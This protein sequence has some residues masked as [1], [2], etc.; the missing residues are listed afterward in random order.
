MPKLEFYDGTS[1]SPM[2]AVASVAVSGSTGLSVSGSPITASGTIALTLGS[3]LQG[4]SGLSA[5][6]IVSRTGIGAFTSRALT[7]GTGITVTNGDGVS[8]NPT[9]ALSTIDINTQT[10]GQLTASR[11]SGY[12]TS[13]SAFLRGDGTWTLPYI[14]NLLINGS[15]NL[16]SYDLA[17]SGTLSATTG[18]VKT[19]N[20]SSY[21][22]GAVVLG[23]P[24]AMNNYAITGLATPSNAQDAANK[25]YVDTN[26]YTKT[27][28]NS[29]FPSNSQALLLGT[30]TSSALSN[31]YI[32][33]NTNASSYGS[34]FSFF[35]NGYGKGEVGYNNST[36]EL[37]LWAVNTS[38]I[39]LGTAGTT[40]LSIASDGLST[41]SSR[42]NITGGQLGF[43]TLAITRTPATTQVNDSALYLRGFYSGATAYYDAAIDPATYAHNFGQV[44]TTRG[45]KY[46]LVIDSNS[47][48]EGSSIA[49]NGD[50]TQ[51][52]NPFDDL[53]IIFTDEDSAN[54]DTYVSYISSSGSLVVSSSNEKKY[55]V[56][57]KE[58]K[59]YLDRIN[60]LN[61]YSYA[62]KCNVNDSDDDKIRNRKYF[63]NKRLNV[64]LIAEEVEHLFENCTDSYK[65]IDIDESNKD[66]FINLTKNHCIDT[67]E[68]EYVDAKNSNRDGPGIRYDTM[69]CY[70]ILALQELSKK[71]DKLTSIRKL[72]LPLEEI[73]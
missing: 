19:N 13:T 72:S 60:S 32:L 29:N 1:W 42:V 39:K 54:A 28:I 53:G 35:N 3:E 52:I 71:V 61:V 64:G 36:S 6:G 5:A 63:K 22:A 48:S 23:S 34:G 12:P 26:F 7:A 14:N 44:T 9:I 38:S 55:S 25:T 15:V 18:T 4:L 50:Y 10:T 70:T 66:D 69:L 8:G 30:N 16:N 33:N 67:E 59:N 40:R 51:L 24:I 27:Y 65:L 46:S 2:G 37:Y 49:M 21:N 47:L 17:T 41:F 68:K 31:T 56:R 45:S 73:K 62:Y 58:H 20:L 57:K 43:S 11:L